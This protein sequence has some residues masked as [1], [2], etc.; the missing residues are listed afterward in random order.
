MLKPLGER[1]KDFQTRVETAY[2][3]ESKERFSLRHEL[4]HLR[5]LNSRLSLEAVNLT[6]ALKGESKTQGTWGEIILERVLEKSGLVKGRE[7]DVQLTLKSE[8]GRR[9]QPMWWF[10]CRKAR[11]SLLTQKYP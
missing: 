8:E 11:I 3:E 2:S 10:I 5:D 6:N 9:Y 4:K 7:Y 1:L